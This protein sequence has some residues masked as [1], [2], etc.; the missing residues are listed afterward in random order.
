MSRTLHLSS[1]EMGLVFGLGGLGGL[2]G[3]VL[4]GRLTARFGVGPIVLMA[5]AL[6]ACVELV[7]AGV[8]GIPIFATGMLVLLETCV[9][10]GATIFGVVA[11]S[12]RQSVTPPR[13]LGRA[14]ASVRFLSVGATPFGAVAAGVLGAVVGVR[15]T[16]ALAGLGTLL[17]AG[18]IVASPVRTLM[19]LPAIEHSA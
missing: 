12:V 8:G 16:V 11:A 3:A 9:E 2:L 15:A 5:L 6:A 19:T 10:F 14:G 13:L 17:A 4:A 7:I 1:F 18:W